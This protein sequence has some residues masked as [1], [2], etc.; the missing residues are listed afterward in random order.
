[1]ILMKHKFKGFLN[2][3]FVL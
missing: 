3:L 2:I 1:M